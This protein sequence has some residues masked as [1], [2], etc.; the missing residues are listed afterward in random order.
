MQHFKFVNWWFRFLMS[1]PGYLPQAFNYLANAGVVVFA[2]QTDD[3]C[4]LGGLLRSNPAKMESFRKFL[5]SLGDIRPLMSASEAEPLF[6]AAESASRSYAIDEMS[7][8]I[9]K[10]ILAKN[11]QKHFFPISGLIGWRSW[12]CAVI[13]WKMKKV[14]LSRYCLRF[15]D[16]VGHQTTYASIGNKHFFTKSFHR[17]TY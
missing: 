6:C 15:F 1:W 13:G 10:S 9:S 4:D 5:A 7:D 11:T 2:L 12:S 16:H 17:Q 14:L 3:L 8:A